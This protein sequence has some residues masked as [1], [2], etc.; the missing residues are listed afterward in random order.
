MQ[1]IRKNPMNNIEYPFR[2]RREGGFSVT[3]LL[4]VVAVLIILTAI[5][6]PYLYSYT[7]KYQSEDQALKMI[8]LMQEAKQMAL[9]RRRTFRFEIDL[10][11]N[12]MLI[13]DENGTDPDT[14]VK[15]I[16]LYNPAEVRVDT[17]PSTVGKPTPPTLND[18][19]FATDGLGHKRGSDTVNGHNV[20]AAR[21]QS[22]GSVVTAGNAPVSAN[23]YIWPPKS[24]GSPDARTFGEVRALTLFGG[25]GG[26]RYWKYNG[27]K[28]VPF[29]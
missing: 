7:Q 15:S 26:L 8:D 25:T 4:M 27:T 6:I 10:T 18:A 12:A 19:V 28:F 3:E 29:Q 20:W 9:T 11:D 5:S 1:V 17:A 2:I 21:F 14:L 24:S 22:N 13:I 23:I 16:P